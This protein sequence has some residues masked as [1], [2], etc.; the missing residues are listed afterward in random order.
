[1]R[2][3]E[4]TRDEWCKIFTGKDIC[5]APVLSLEES[6]NNQ[7]NLD[8]ETFVEVAGIKQPAPAP[9]FSRTE[10]EIKHPP[11][12]VGSNTPEIIES[13]SSKID[14]SVLTDQKIIRLD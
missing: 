4:K 6:L 12:K 8:R 9:R 14:V 2:F 1:M 7:H 10:S 11:L 3:K 5:F 13:L